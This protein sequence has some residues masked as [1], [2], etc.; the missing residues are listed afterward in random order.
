MTGRGSGACR[1]VVGAATRA[2]GRGSLCVGRRGAEAGREC[3]G[4]IRHEQTNHLD[5]GL[6]GKTVFELRSRPRARAHTRR[7]RHRIGPCAVSVGAALHRDAL[8]PP[9]AKTIIVVA[10][11]GGAERQSGAV[12]AAPP[13]HPAA[14]WAA[15][16]SPSMF[17]SCLVSLGRGSPKLMSHRVGPPRCPPSPARLVG[18]LRLAAPIRSFSFGFLS[19]LCLGCWSFLLFFWCCPFVPFSSFFS[20][21]SFLPPLLP[22]FLFFS[23]SRPLPALL[24]IVR[25]DAAVPSSP[26][27]THLSRDPP[28]SPPPPPPEAA[29]PPPPSQRIPSYKMTRPN[30]PTRGQEATDDDDRSPHPRRPPPR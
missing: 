19:L 30:P 27:A 18:L 29:R 21:F 23:S 3:G 1:V 5:R 17:A 14:R 6:G 26:A 10:G 24:P 4:I 9:G 13:G 8:A 20:S 16:V 25:S 12:G 2:P 28:S 15:C 22:S 11:V 7:S